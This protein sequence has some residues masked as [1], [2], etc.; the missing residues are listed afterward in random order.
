[1]A[2][3]IPSNIAVTHVFRTKFFVAGSNDEPERPAAG[4]YFPWNSSGRSWRWLELASQILMCARGLPVATSNVAAMIC[5][6]ARMP[7]E[8]GP[9]ASQ[10]ALTIQSRLGAPG[11]SCGNKL[12]VGRTRLQAMN[13]DGA[14]GSFEHRT[15]SRLQNKILRSR[16]LTMSLSDRPPATISVGTHPVAPGDG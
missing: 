16:A 2:L 3:A 11:T 1:M 15:D 7:N 8:D 9:G 5:K 14:G 10:V 12:F 13:E 4:D 6:R